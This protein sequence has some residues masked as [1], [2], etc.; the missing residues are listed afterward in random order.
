MKKPGRK[1]LVSGTLAKRVLV[2][3]DQPTI[4]KGKVIGN[5]NLSRGIRTAIHRRRVRKSS[6]EPV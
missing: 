4:D 2:T 5:G 6:M 1:P 3:L